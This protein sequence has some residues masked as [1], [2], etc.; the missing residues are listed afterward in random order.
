LLS[1]SFTLCSRAIIACLYASSSLEGGAPTE[2]VPQQRERVASVDDVKEPSLTVEG[3]VVRDGLEKRF[4]I[5]GLRRS[6]LHLCLRSTLRAWIWSSA[7][8]LCPAHAV[9]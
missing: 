4:D 5:A 9:T 3:K 8:R 1:Q 2:E 6:I 7:S